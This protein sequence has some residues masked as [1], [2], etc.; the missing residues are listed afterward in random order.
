MQRGWRD[1]PPGGKL[2]DPVVV[3]DVIPVVNR[4]A[5]GLAQRLK[6]I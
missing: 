2:Y 5:H 6:F 1:Q 3:D 4:H